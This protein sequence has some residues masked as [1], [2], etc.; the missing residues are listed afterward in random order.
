MR[1]RLLRGVI[2]LALVGPV[3]AQLPPLRI[4]EGIGVNIHFVTGHEADLDMIAAAGFRWVR[5][6]FTWEAIERRRG[7]YDWSGY[8]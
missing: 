6:D 5:M 3:F 4:P 7:E 2:L 8:D 1:A